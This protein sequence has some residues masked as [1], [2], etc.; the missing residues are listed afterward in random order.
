M[1]SSEPLHRKSLNSCLLGNA[2]NGEQQ[3]GR[4]WSNPMVEQT[5]SKKRVKTTRLILHIQ[6]MYMYNYPIEMVN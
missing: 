4:L 3:I 6:V 5:R 1:L 2:P